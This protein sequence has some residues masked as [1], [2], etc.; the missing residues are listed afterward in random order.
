MK[1]LLSIILILSSFFS[2]GQGPNTTIITISGVK[3]IVTIPDDYSSTTKNYPFIMFF[4][5]LGEGG[6][7]PS[8]IYNSS[9]AGGPSYYVAH[10][11]WP[12]SFTNPADGQQY[13][14]IIV[15]PQGPAGQGVSWAAMDVII[16]YMIANYRVDMNRFSMTG[17][18]E[19]GQNV[20]VYTIGCCGVTPQHT[21]TTIMP[22]SMAGGKPDQA[23]CNVTISKGVHAWGFGSPNTDGLGLNTQLWMLGNQP[24]NSCNCTGLVAAGLG[25]FTNYSGGHCCWG[26]FYDP[27]YREV[28]GGVSMNMYEWSLQYSAGSTNLPPVVNAGSNQTVTLPQDSVTLT[29]SATDQDGTI[30]SYAWTQVSGTAAT[31]VSPTATTTKIRGLSTSGVRTFKLT[32]TDNSS[33]T[34]SANVSITSNPAVTTVVSNAPYAPQYPAAKIVKVGVGEYQTTYLHSDGTVHFWGFPGHYQYM[35]FGLVG[36]KDVVGQQ[37]DN[38]ALLNDGTVRKISKANNGSPLVI[39]IPVDTFGRKFDSVQYIEGMYQSSVFIRHDSLYYLGLGNNLTYGTMGL[40]TAILTKPMPLGQPVGRK[41]IKIVVFEQ[42]SAGMPVILALCSDGTVWTYSVGSIN[43]TQITGFTGPA[44]DITGVTRA[45][46]CIITATDILAWGP[47]ASYFGLADFT[48]VPTSVLTSFTNKGLVMPIRKSISSYNS[49]HFIDANDNLFAEGDNAQGEIG[50]GA[51]INPWRTYK[52]GTGTAPF[53]W[54]FAKGQLMSAVV[55]IPGKWAN[56]FGGDNIAFGFFGQDI[57]YK[58]G[59]DSAL[60]SWGRGKNDFLGNG[61]RAGNDDVY[62]C[63]G[64][65]PAPRYVSPSNVAHVPDFAFAPDNTFDPLPNAGIDQYINSSTTTLFGSGSSQPEG[66]IS[67]Y[68]WSKISGSGAVTSPT[69]ANTSV[70]GLSG[71]ALFKL[72]VTNNT[73]VSKSDTIK[74]FSSGTTTPPNVSA[75]NDQSIST[76][77]TTLSGTASGNG[78]VITA[79]NWTQLTGPNIANLVTPNSISTVISGLTF[80]TYVFQLQGSDSDFQTSYDQVQVIVGSSTPI[81]NGIIKTRGHT[82]KIIRL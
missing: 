37:Y 38:L 45:A 1:K 47:F 55:Q 3:C 63:W 5:G 24:G 4:H 20:F 77:S 15:T 57:G 51:Q 74:V 54:D 31:I 27:N 73:G 9:T 48:T 35:D 53:A 79:L 6:T 17:L 11:L 69:S 19:G 13:K 21:P 42:A 18:S 16:N 61:I 67:S 30:V 8:V 50:T 28:I 82:I 68:A 59:V 66:S 64:I 34:G 33:N 43:P 65:I 40:G 32:A 60:Y 22:M 29:G 72:T 41:L 76:N 81:F 25:R 26:Q 44:V 7:D 80:G 71:S 14:F 78:T 46:F 2:Y 49:I 12:S 39:D 10:N 75:G 52:N 56:V 23:A 62:A 70:T 36:V 58:Y